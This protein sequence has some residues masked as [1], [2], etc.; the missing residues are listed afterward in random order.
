MPQLHLSL[1]K[2]LSNFPFQ[3]FAADAHQLLGGYA[4]IEKCK[5]R[6]TLVEAI[7]IGSNIGAKAFIHL[8]LALL[9]RPE[10]VLQEIGQK[11]Y[12]LL[13]AYSEPALKAQS[14]AA[15]VNLELRILSHY[16]QP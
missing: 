14:L 3:A 5:T 6:L 13:Q 1:S 9:P 2:N 16:W 12:Q 11:L 8:E 4:K 15:D 7:H 10:A